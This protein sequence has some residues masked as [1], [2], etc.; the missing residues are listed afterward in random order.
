MPPHGTTFQPCGSFVA[1]VTKTRE[2]CSVPLRTVFSEFFDDFCI[3]LGQFLHS[4][5]NFF[6]ECGCCRNIPHGSMFGFVRKMEE[7]REVPDGVALCLRE[8]DG[9]KHG[10]IDPWM[11]LERETLPFKHLEIKENILSD[12]HGSFDEFLHFLFFERRLSNKIFRMNARECVR[13]GRNRYRHT[14]EP[15]ILGHL[16]SLLKSDQCELD[17]SITLRNKPCCFGIQNNKGKMRE[18]H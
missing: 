3:S 1:F 16:L 12:D 9:G 8:D 6:N 14:V 4:L 15:L 2:P 17:H 18:W 7:R 13:H 11:L 5:P 10:G